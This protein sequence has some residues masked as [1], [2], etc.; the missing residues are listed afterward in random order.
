MLGLAALRFLLP[1]GKLAGEFLFGPVNIFSVVFRQGTELRNDNG[2]TNILLLGI[3][4]TGH[5]GPTLTD[6]MILLSIKNRPDESKTNLSPAVIISIPRDIYLG[7]LG[8]KINSAYD[9]GL[10]QGVGTLLVKSAVEQ[11]TGFPIHYAVVA[12]FSVFEEVVNTL[13]GIDVK[14]MD[15]LDDPGYP[16]AGKETDTCGYPPEEVA[17][18]SASISLSPTSEIDAFPCRYESLHFDTGR[19]HMDGA[20]ALKFVRSRHAQGD[21]G[22]DFARSRRQQLVLKAIKDKVLSSQTLLSPG[23]IYDIYSQLKSHIRSDLDSVEI[24]MLVNLFLKYRTAQIKTA[25]IDQSLLENPPVDQRGWILL[26]KGG[27]WDQ[28]HNFVKK[29]LESQ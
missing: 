16:I 1:A 22:T 14:V 21:E 25:A 15:T 17:T 11:V 18:R 28:V 5:E 27:N 12:D 29:Q 26:P 19:Q 20:T 8:D 2:R 7:S 24:N 3:G 10:K 13:G 23:K 6:A 4:G 9:T